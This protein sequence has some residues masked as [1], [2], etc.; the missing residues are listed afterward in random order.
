MSNIKVIK[1]DAIIDIKIGTGF[2]QK[3]QKLMIHIIA[4]VTPEQLAEYK[5]E[6]ENFKQDSEFSEDWMEH[7]TTISVLVKE[8]E[9]Q[10]ETQGYTYDRD[11][12][13]IEEN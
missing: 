4:D 7:L 1:K 13:S 8:I 2:L 10:A 9:Q 5:K 11:E 3:L 6:A 12:S